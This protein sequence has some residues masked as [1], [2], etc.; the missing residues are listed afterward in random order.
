MEVSVTR[1]VGVLL[2]VALGIASPVMAGEVVENQS[3]SGE[4]TT[5]G[6]AMWGGAGELTLA[7]KI[8]TGFV[9]Q[10]PH[11]A[12]ELNVYPWGQYWAKLQTQAASGLAPDVISMFSTNVG[13]WINHGA[14][15]PL[16]D[17]VAASGTNLDDYYQTSI[18]NFVWHGKLYAFPLELAFSTL[19]YSIDRLE[20]SGVPRKNG[21]SRTAPCGGRSSCN[22]PV[23]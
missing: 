23:G 15:L 20:E 8:C 12:V 10:Y 13:V 6:Y 3:Y 19:V 11:I 7:R 9:A 21:R 2:L 4:K 14:L 5:I 17:L 22:S 1:R 18:D 16:D